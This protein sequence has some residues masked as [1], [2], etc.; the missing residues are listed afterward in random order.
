MAHQK[1]D[2]V[3]Y[4]TKNW[5]DKGTNA[6]NGTQNLTFYYDAAGIKAANAKKVY[7]QFADTRQM[8]K[9]RGREYRV[10][11][12]F[13]IND[14]PLYD[15]ATTDVIGGQKKFDADFLKYGYITSRNIADVTADTYGTDGRFPTATT[16]ANNGKR[17]LEGEREGNTVTIRKTT[18]NAYL[19]KFGQSLDYTDEV[20]L[21]SEDNMQ[22][23]YREELGYA[24]GQLYEDLLQMD[25]LAT[26]TQM[27]AGT[28]TSL[29]TLGAGIAQGT[30]D[31]VTGVNAI[32]ESYKVSYELIQKVATKLFRNRAP[33]HT[34]LLKGSTNIGTTPVSAC[35]VAIVGPEVKIDLENMVRGTTYEK[36]YCF[37][38]V[39]TYAS[40]TQVIE[41]EFGRVN[42]IRFVLSETAM[43][44]RGA[45]AIVDGN[46]IGTLSHS[47]IKNA[48]NQD[49]DRFD[50][51]PILIPCKESFATISL[52]GE[53]KIKFYS[54]APEDIDKTDRFG[55]I[56]FFA[57]KFWYASIITRPE[58]L[59]RVN[60]LAS[61]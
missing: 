23:K 30:P 15:D 3:V 36:S 12:W 31:A 60:V 17:L 38:P 25:M 20:R 19:E 40:Q 47:V 50:V 53:D 59:I 46:Y 58:R 52:Q 22:I 54:K 35:Y 61:A 43:V 42:D 4:N 1:P 41:G 49:E 51:F 27:Y 57:Y 7:Q 10:D 56:G 44:A 39:E 16:F 11:V 5:Y 2:S 8:S 9:N 13:H 26:P 24:A 14:R 21:F 33:K 6:A 18:I 32:E 29:A 55:A 48:Q 34:S 37:D 28:A 45:G